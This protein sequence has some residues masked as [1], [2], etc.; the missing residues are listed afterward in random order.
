MT[1]E[2]LEEGSTYSIEWIDG[3]YKTN[4]IFIREHRGFLIF[5]DSNGSRVF[6]RPTSIKSL[7]L[8]KG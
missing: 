4:C 7:T 2:E 8:L 3:D 5:E 6:C 1:T